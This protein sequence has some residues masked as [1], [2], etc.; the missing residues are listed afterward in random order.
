MLKPYSKRGP[1]TYVAANR[2]ADALD[3]FPTL[4]MAVQ[5]VR[6][7]GRHGAHRLVTRDHHLAIEAFP[8]S[9]SSFAH[10][11]FT[12]ANPDSAKLV[13]THIHRSAQVI[14]AARLGVPT[15]VLVRPPES[16]V[17]SLL[18][19]GIQKGQLPQMAPD[20]LRACMAES[21]RRYVNFHSRI[22][23]VE[24]MVVA[25]FEDVVTDYG[26]IIGQ[27]NAR[28]G[29]AFT[30][31]I[32]DTETVAEVFGAG[33]DHLAPSEE[34]DSL[35]TELRDTYLAP[36]LAGLRARAE[37][38]HARLAARAATPSAAAE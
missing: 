23:P 28:F 13:A 27:I 16:T 9:G 12:R 38:V 36:P 30:K 6:Q 25:R 4:Y 11:A 35:K 29:T 33:R 3:R 17:T 20:D 2:L 22:E 19:M 8:R 18:A 26:R 31:F 10:M 21:L 5:R 15:L 24:D 1:R 37:D 7:R 34:R 14:T 32:H